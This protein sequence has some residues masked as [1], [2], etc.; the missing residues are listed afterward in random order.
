MSSCIHTNCS[1]TGAW[2]TCAWL[3]KS[4]TI[5]YNSLRG[6]KTC[7][8]HHFFTSY[9]SLPPY[10]N[11][12]AAP[13]NC[14]GILGLR[15]QCGCI[16]HIPSH[17]DHTYTPTHTY[18][19]LSY[20]CTPYPQAWSATPRLTDRPHT[21]HYTCTFPATCCTIRSLSHFL[22]YS[23]L[24]RTITY[25]QRRVESDV[26]E[27]HSCY[28]VYANSILTYCLYTWLYPISMMRLPMLCASEE[29]EYQQ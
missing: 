29:T 27:I 12:V 17:A 19:I 6:R 14:I 16:S 9:S 2:S 3:S 10:H 25:H 24:M 20:M 28:W 13:G 22:L 21:L 15:V 8:T 11:T 7:T 4:G 5:Y 1:Q 26:I 18:Y 23:E